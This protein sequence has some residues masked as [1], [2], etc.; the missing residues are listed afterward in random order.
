ML[1]IY[2]I[3]PLK[4]ILPYDITVSSS[5]RCK[6]DQHEVEIFQSNAIDVTMTTNCPSRAIG[7]F[8]VIL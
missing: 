4:I 1:P 7:V 5:F 8:K 6:L 2:N 3:I